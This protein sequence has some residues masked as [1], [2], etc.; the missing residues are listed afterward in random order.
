MIK[1]GNSLC[2]LVWCK[3][4][5]LLCV[6]SAGRN[7]IWVKF[8]EIYGSPPCSNCLLPAGSPVRA[9]VSS[10][11]NGW[12]RWDS[13]LFKSEGYGDKWWP[14]PLPA[15]I[16]RSSTWPWM[17]MLEFHYGSQRKKKRKKENSTAEIWRTF[18]SQTSCSVRLGLIC[19]SKMLWNDF[20]VKYPT[21]I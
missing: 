12:S 6:S 4:K 3:W 14:W 9:H 21:K 17:D 7:G 16:Q 18:S 10:S 15:K 5:G 8:M 13:A 19:A 1:A 20:I 11:R 2:S